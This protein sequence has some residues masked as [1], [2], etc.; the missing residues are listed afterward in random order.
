M[1]TA[2]RRPTKASLNVAVAI[3]AAITSMMN[4]ISSGSLIGVRKRTID[5]AP[6]R[7]S[8]SGSE[9]WMQ[10]KIAVIDRPSSGN[11]RYTWLPVARDE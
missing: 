11:A 8:E 1:A 7:P 9:N 6:S 10:M 4:P 2:N 3:E 5:S